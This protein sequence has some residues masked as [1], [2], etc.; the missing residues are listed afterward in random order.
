MARGYDGAFGGKKINSAAVWLGFCLL[1][2]VGLADLRRPLSMRNLDLL[3]LLS[4]SVSLWFFNRGDI[5]TSVPLVYPPLVYLLGRMVWSG[6]RGRLA[7]RLGARLADLG[8][9]GRDGLHGRFPH[10]P[11]RARLER[12]RRR[13][14]G[15]DRREPDRERPVALW[16]LPGRGHAEGV[17]EGRLRGRDPRAHPDERPLR[18][19]QPTGR[20]VRPRRLRGLPARLPDPRLDGEVG[21]SSGGAPELDPL[22]P[23]LPAGPGA[24]RPALRR[25][26][27]GRDARLRLGRL[28]VHA[29]RLELEHERR[30]AAALPDL[31]LLAGDLSVGPW[32]CGRR[33]PAGRSSRRCCSRR[34]GRPT[35]SGVRAR[36]GLFLAGFLAATAVAFSILLLE[37]SPV[38]AAKDFWDRTLGW[39][40]G[41]QSPFSIWDWGQYH[42][43]PARPPRPPASARRPAG[44]GRDRPRTSCRAG[45]RRYSS[46]R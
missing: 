37:P 39:Q 8:A 17:R 42:A 41:R 35:P 7:H 46:R 21:R 26:P 33:S 13:L 34:C 14:L 4:F 24:R 38:Q 10:R 15:R 23:A 31:G 27:A 19:G 16:P 12:D 32:R 25:H 30:P 22:R 6:W 45:N 36:R 20:H 1:F 18:V 28:P 29:V 3:A 9:G 44:G 11:E 43:G 5:F 40:I 2:L